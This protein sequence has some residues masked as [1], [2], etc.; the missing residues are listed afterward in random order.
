MQN[1]IFV[2]SESAI[3]SIE[4]GNTSY[5]N[6]GKL[7]NEHGPAYISADESVMEWWIRGVQQP[8]PSNWED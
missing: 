8:K 2:Q 7:H 1:Q 6:W 5:L 4:N 3:I